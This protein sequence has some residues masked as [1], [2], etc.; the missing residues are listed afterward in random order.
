MIREILDTP[1]IDLDIDVDSSRLIYEYEKV[2]NKYSFASYQ[3][4]FWPVRRKYA[5]SWSGICLISSDGGLYSDMYEGSQ[6]KTNKTELA[7]LC[8]YMYD[9]IHS[10]GGS[11]FNHRARLLRIAP[12]ESLVWHNHT[13]EHGQPE[14]M[15]TVQI[16]IVVPEGFEYNVVFNED[17]RWYKRFSKGSSFKNRAVKKPK[18]GD[19][20][21]F[22]SFHYH[23]VFNP[24]DKYRATLMF[25][26]SYN[27]PH[28]RQ[29]VDRSLYKQREKQKLRE[30]NV[31]DR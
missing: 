16:P 15:L 20:F 30:I 21:I 8:P 12:G 26:I 27:N 17:F 13:F 10:I 18:P 7:D 19:A 3:T 4:K 2:E 24:S 28:V 22:N 1:F 29:L 5:R 6:S 31:P 9:L 25:Y 23:N 14:T 11:N